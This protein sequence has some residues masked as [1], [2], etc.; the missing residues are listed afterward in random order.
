MMN[1]PMHGMNE[2]MRRAIQDSLDCAWACTETVQHCLQ[3]GGKHAD[4][5]HIG[6]LLD[7]AEACR[8]AA[9][10]MA[11]GSALHP[12]SC[13][14]CADACL[15]CARSCEQIDPNDQ[16]MRACADACRRCEA[17]CRPM[18]GTGHSRMAA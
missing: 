12:Q 11:R 5:Q 3:L 1:Q 6:T 9:D 14:L 17:S 10:F 16:M 15:D 7:C 8:T 18:A 13:L 4:A 2:S